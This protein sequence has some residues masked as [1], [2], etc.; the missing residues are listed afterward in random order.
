LEALLDAGLHDAMLRRPVL[1]PDQ[2]EQMDR[3]LIRIAGYR[4]E[5]PRRIDE[6]DQH[7]AVV[8]MK[9]EVDSFLEGYRHAEEGVEP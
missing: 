7:A 5:F 9:R 8:Q 3:V 1:P 6:A 2:Q 4:R